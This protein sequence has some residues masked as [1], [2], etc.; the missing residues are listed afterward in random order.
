MASV[1][2]SRAI[3]SRTTSSLVNH[4]LQA[5]AS[6][7]VTAAQ[8]D[9]NVAWDNA[10]PFEKI[11]GPKPLPLIGNLHRFIP[12]IGE[13]STKDQLH[14]QKHLLEKYGKIVKI[15]GIPGRRDMVMVYDPKWFEEMFRNESMWPHREFLQSLDYYRNVYRKDFF[16]GVGGVLVEQGERWKKFRS[17]VNP[18]MMQPR[19]ALRYLKPITEVTND[20]IKRTKSLRNSVGEMPD[21]F[22]NELFKWALESIAVI[23]L[24]HR[25]GCLDPNLKADS[26]PQKMIDAVSD[27]FAGLEVMELRPPLWKIMSTPTWRRF[28]RA[29]DYFT[30][31]SMKHINNA[32]ERMNNRKPGED[33]EPS[34]LE[35]LLQ[36]DPNPKTACVMA[37]DMLIAGVD[38]TNVIMPHLSLSN[39]EEYNPLP[40]QF[41]PERWLKSRPGTDGSVGSAEDYDKV[42]DFKMNPFTY[43]PFGFGPRMCV[44][45]RFA[46]LEFAVLI[47]KMVRHFHI[48]YN[49][50]D[51]MFSS[52]LLHKPADP[53]KF[54]LTDRVY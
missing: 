46:E 34:V 9:G 53:L 4:A 48:D 40:S 44:G 38:T 10:R 42:K 35:K 37:I 45:K 23:A 52:V 30:D 6:V 39:T 15:T 8:V 32:I 28:A 16:E 5:S 3:K 2:L 20:L 17:T 36:R 25:L 27:F 13:L 22:I 50:G 18:P 47:T 54:K 11:P 21:D 51:M 19:V 14:M 41:I 12:G 26:E 29:M 33:Y 31:V 24:D 7:Q 43:L 49:Y 1:V